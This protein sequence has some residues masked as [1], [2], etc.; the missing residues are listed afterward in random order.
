MLPPDVRQHVAARL[1]LI[2]KGSLIPVESVW[3]LLEGDVSGSTPS[4]AAPTTDEMTVEMIAQEMNRAHSTVRGWFERGEI[5]GAYRF[6]GRE[7][8]A[9]R[10]AFNAFRDRQRAPKQH[11]TTPTTGPVDLGSWRNLKKAS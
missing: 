5:E 2:P 3:E 8:R 4:A 6:K 9:P 11:A 1:R 10:A 7:W